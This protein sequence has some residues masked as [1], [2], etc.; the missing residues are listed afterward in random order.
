M[1]R[2][3]GRTISFRSSKYINTQIGFEGQD[4]SS[5][6]LTGDRGIFISN[7]GERHI[8]RLD[9]IAHKKRRVRLNPE[10]LDDALARW[11][12]VAA[13]DDS[14]DLEQLDSISGGDGESTRK[15]KYYKSLDNP[16]SLFPEVQ[17]TFLNETLRHHGLGY[18][19]SAQKCAV[20]DCAVGSDV[21]FFRCGSCGYF[22]QCQTCCI[23]RHR[24]TPLHF[25][26]E[27]NGKFWVQTTLKDIGLVYQLGHEGL[28]CLVPHPVVWTLTVIDVTGIHTIH[29]RFCGCARS[30]RANNLAQLLRN[31]WYPASFTNPDTCATFRVLDLFRQLSVVGNMNVRDFVTTLEQLTDAMVG[32]GLKWMP[33]CAGFGAAFRLMARQYAFL[34][35]VRRGGRGHDPA[36]L[37][38]TKAGECMVICWACPYDGRNLPVNWRDVDPN[39]L[40]RLIVALD[41]NFKIKNRIRA[42]EHDDPS[43]GP[44]WGVFVAPTQYKKHLRNYVAEKDISTCIAFVALTQKDTRNTAGLHVLGVGGCV[45]ARHE[46]MRPNGLGD[47]QK[48][49]CY[50]NMDYILMSALAGCDLTELTLS[51][52]IACQWK[53]NFAE[54]MAHLPEA[55]C[56]DLEA[57][58]VQTGLPVWHTLAH[59]EMCTSLNS[60]NY[61]L[62]VGRSDGEGIERLWAWLNG[63]AY[64]SKEMGLGNRADTIEDKLDSHNFQKNLGKADALRRKLIVADVERARQVVAFKEINKTIPYNT[65]VKWQKKIDA[66]MGD[67]AAPNPY[68]LANKRG[69][70]EAE[71]RA[72]LKREEQEAV[73]KGESPLH[74]TSAT[75]FLSA[76][77]QLEES[78]RRIKA[79][80]EAGNLTANREGKIEEHRIAFMAKLKRFRTLQAVYTPA[81]VRMIQAEEAGRD[82]DLPALSA[83]HIKLWLPSQLPAAQRVG[84]GCQRNIVDMEATLREG[85]A[86]NAL[87]T[88]RGRLHSKRFIINFRNKNLTG[89]KK[90]T[91]AHTIIKQLTERI[92]VAARKYRDARAAL[93]SLKGANYAPHLKVL[94][95]TDIILE[96]ENARDSSEVAQSDCAAVKKLAR[97]GGQGAQ[98]HRNDTSKGK[99]PGVSWIW[100][101]QHGSG[102]GVDVLQEDLDESLRVD[103]SRAKTRKSRWDE[104][105]ELLREEMCRVLRYLEWEKA[106]W[107][108]LEKRVAEHQDMTIDIR[109]GLTAYASK[110][111]DLFERLYRLFR[112]QMGV[113]LAEATSLVFALEN[114]EAVAS[115]FTEGVFLIEM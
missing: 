80:L 52:D 61:I 8:E 103:W 30:D 82:P 13:E 84:S 96:G 31:T 60:L 16:M 33:V 97:V 47:L 64:Q 42:R 111:A 27:W 101:S 37:A 44:G 99:A 18:S 81:A 74:A 43:L 6:Q 110:Q 19:C 41:A 21:R 25:L 34:Q 105:V 72:S 7:D 20:C 67:R 102:D 11:I 98:P 45:C 106:R 5:S 29:Y 107:A 85:Q 54:R 53:K 38:A 28:K 78:Q 9:N 114:D 71:L 32:T 112:Q 95:A 70:T 57:I 77:L 94:K 15:R 66:F 12:P 14:L 24:W 113:P 48:G 100:L 3:T 51:S 59:E 86:E 26:E 23:E 62:G 10:A 75:A 55:L 40:F 73:K 17:Q 108:D 90:T 36:G 92:E 63:C 4:A 2:N 65:R 83:K 58:D 76:G 68:I 87:V 115:L 49:E 1:L 79:E 22:I 56:L 109:A 104:E 93:T 50:A 88:I 35:R 39:Y 89:Q 91:R 69:P 46:C